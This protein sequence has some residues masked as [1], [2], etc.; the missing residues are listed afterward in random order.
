MP[1]WLALAALAVAAAVFAA[2]WWGSNV[3]FNPPRMLPN[4]V[5]PEQFSLPYEKVSFPSLDGVTLAG[6]IIPASVATDKTIMMC[7]GWGDNKGDILRRFHFLARDYNLFLFDSRHHG[8]SAG[9]I[10]TIGCL[11]ARDFTAALEWFK[12]NHPAWTR[13]LGLLGLSMG[14]AMAIRGLAVHGGFRCALLESPFRSFN[15]VIHQFS[16]NAYKLPYYPFVWLTLVI[17][18]WRIG[19]DPEPYSPGLHAPKMPAIPLLFIAGEKD[20]LMPL[21]EVRAVF[22]ASPSP[23]ELWVVPEGT[24]GRC[25]EAAEAEY[26]RRVRGFFAGGL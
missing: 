16:T 4:A 21:G 5:F 20:Q 3:V 25:Q 8:E 19:E 24:H 23:K 7:H 26:E 12:A 1:A 2:C 6:W 17:I 14:A 9:D 22:D 15:R 11:E 13:R 18:R 10:S